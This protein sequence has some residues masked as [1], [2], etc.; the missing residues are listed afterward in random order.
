MPESKTI[1]ASFRNGTI[2]DLNKQFKQEHWL[3]RNIK[4]SMLGNTNITEASADC[5]N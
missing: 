4:N 5:C 1:T 3:F 2:F